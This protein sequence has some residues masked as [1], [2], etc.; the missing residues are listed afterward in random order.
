MLKVQM[1]NGQTETFDLRQVGDFER[2]VDIQK[3]SEKQAQI[4][5]VG[6][7]HDGMWHVMPTPK[8]FKRINY[9]AWIDYIGKNGDRAPASLKIKCQAD[10]ISIM[11]VLYYPNGKSPRMVRTDIKKTG[12][13][14]F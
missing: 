9:E 13:Q 8:K 11:M 7:Q 14:V 1:A 5:A 6:V 4:R 2:W 10:N 3:D 12:R